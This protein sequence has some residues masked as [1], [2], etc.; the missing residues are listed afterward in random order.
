M[1]KILICYGT[2][3]EYIKIEPILLNELI[4]H[5]DISTLFTGQ[6]RDIGEGVVKPDSVS[7]THLTLPTKA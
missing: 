5:H 6:H 7:Y 1:K 4:Q 3:P 2:R